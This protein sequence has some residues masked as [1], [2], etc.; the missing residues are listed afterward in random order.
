MV[1]VDTVQRA[2]DDGQ[3]DQST[4]PRGTQ[5]RRPRLREG[6]RHPTHRVDPARLALPPGQPSHLPARAAVTL[7]ARCGRKQCG[8][9]TDGGRGGSDGVADDRATDRSVLPV[10]VRD[11]TQTHAYRLRTDPRRRRQHSAATAH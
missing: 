9:W 5:R 7:L 3:A 10:R 1:C 11:S 2:V 6:R 8:D 4:V